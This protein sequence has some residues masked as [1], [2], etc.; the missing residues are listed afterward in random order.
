MGQKMVTLLIAFLV[1]TMIFADMPPNDVPDDNPGLSNINEKQFHDLIQ[2]VN[3]TYQPI[4]KGIGVNFWF[5][6]KWD[7]KDSNMYVYQFDSQYAK[8]WKIEVHGGLARKVQIT[9]EGF[10]MALCH[11]IGHLLGGYPIKDYLKSS[12]EGQADYY[13]AHVCAR[14]IFGKTIKKRKLINQLRIESDLCE[15]YFDEKYDKDVCMLTLMGAKS[16]SDFLAVVYRP[17]I[18]ETDPTTPEQNDVKKT[19]QGHPT[20]QCRLDT[21]IAGILCD[22]PWDDKI[23]PLDKKAKTCSNR[24]KCWYAP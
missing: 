6:R 14:K 15:K 10:T 24:P 13:A 7:S 2:S 20:P 4:F 12:T 17:W 8:N 18:K 19:F 5:E 9:K 1:S 23:I 22:K 21:M 16:L 11:E 3:D